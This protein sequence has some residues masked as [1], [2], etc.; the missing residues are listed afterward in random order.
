MDPNVTVS[1]VKRSSFSCL[2]ASWILGVGLVVQRISVAE[3]RTIVGVY[4]SGWIV[5]EGRCRS[6][7]ALLWIT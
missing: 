7:Q 2:T 5:E 3:M 1:Y 6:V 4:E